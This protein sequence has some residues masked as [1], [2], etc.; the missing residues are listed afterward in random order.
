MSDYSQSPLAPKP[1]PV[2]KW[3][4]KSSK[5]FDDFTS[6]KEYFDTLPTFKETDD[7]KKR[8]RLRPEGHF[9]VILYEPPPKPKKEK[10][11]EEAA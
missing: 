11:E 9:D 6:A 8:I 4:Q 7:G 5:R 1:V 10:V 3:R 2:Q